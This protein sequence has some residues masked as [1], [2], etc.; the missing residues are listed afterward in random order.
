MKKIININLS[1]RVIP[2]EDSAYE[3]LQ[4]YIESLR[5]YFANEEGRDEIINDIESRIAELMN[6][7]VRRGATAVTDADIE[8]IISSMGRIEDFERTDA[9]EKAFAASGQTTSGTYTQTQAEPKRAKGR[10]YRD[11][12]DKFLGGVCAGIANYMNVDPAIVRLLFAIITFG[13]FG[14]GILIYLALWI[15]LPVRELDTYV[16]KRLF[17][18]PDDRV[19]SGVAGGLGAYFNKP[20]WAFRLIF[21][22]PLLLNILFGV[23]N[24]IF[25]MWQRDIFPNIFIGSFSGTFVLA[26]IILWIV[27]PEARSPFEK[28]EMRGEKID[29]NR[30]K[31]N[32]QEGMGDF[33]QRMQSWGEEVK[34]SAQNLGARAS[35]FAN[36]RGK[37]FASDVSDTARPAGRGCLHA[38]AVIIK[39]FF[40]F[41]AGCITLSLFAALM[42][43]LFGGIAWWPINNFLW[44]SSLQKALAWG[45]LIFFIGVPIIG[46]MTWLIRRVVRVRSHSRYL[47]WIFGGLWTFGWICAVFFAVSIAKDLRDYQRISTDV[48]LTQPAG[49]KLIVNV[50]EPE[51][52]YNGG[53]FNWI[54][55]DNTGWDISEDTLTYNNVKLRISKSEDSLYHAYTYRYSFG[56]S[57]KDAQ[58]RAEKI[59]FN[60]S[61]QD[62]MLNLASGLRIYRTS[63]FRGQ[64]VILE[65]QVPAGKAIRFNESLVDAYNP[66]VVRRASK[67]NRYWRRNS[68]NIDWDYDDYFDWDANVD[69]VM[70]TDGKLIKAD[71]VVIDSTGVYEKK[72]DKNKLK[73][74]EE[75]ERKNEK[76]RQEIERE[77][78]KLQQQNPVDSAIGYHQSKKK[79]SD[80][81]MLSIFTPLII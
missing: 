62:S 66:W 12:S 24:G 74:L 70:G 37:A 46:F 9:E 64:G 52:H 32:V 14:M 60:T 29:V 33:K 79:E 39:A 69:Y 21:A 25:F 56:S 16:G 68:Y 31:Q 42:A 65:I 73:D 51:I 5:R 76:E 8:E 22:A 20:S 34:T 15:I 6:D 50:N 17:R 38:I 28:M 35:E 59:I 48:A 53:G 63:K 26:Y 19:I 81:A 49:G 11:G 55:H 41:V 58:A 10:L 44:T 80:V 4:R 78:E 43:I 13:G 47:G 7:K 54:R 67:E 57:V 3:S 75:K 2:I 71:K 72:S 1:G 36:T 18:N 61:S 77:K 45:T 40:I 27:L 23:L 30:I